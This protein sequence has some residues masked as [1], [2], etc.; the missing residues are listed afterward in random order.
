MLSGQRLY[1]CGS[2]PARQGRALTR[3]SRMVGS[4]WSWSAP[5]RWC[6]WCRCRECCWTSHC[7]LMQEAASRGTRVSPCMWHVLQ[8]AM[9]AWQ[10][11]RLQYSSPV[12]AT[13][14]SCNNQCEWSI[15]AQS[16][17]HQWLNP[18]QSLSMSALGQRNP[19]IDCAGLMCG[20]TTKGLRCKTLPEV[21][22]IRG[23]SA[24]S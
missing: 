7:A 6:C 21:Q 22:H 2:A 20:H 4:Q 19:S 16:M 23:K 12:A 8:P 5:G 10:A 14:I 24:P 18:Q 1:M 9:Y 17:P 13:T 15:C 11:A 3:T